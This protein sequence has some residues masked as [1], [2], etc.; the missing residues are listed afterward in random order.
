[1]I[2]RVAPFVFVPTNNIALYRS[3]ERLIVSEI[4]PQESF[5][6]AHE[7]LILGPKL[8][9]NVGTDRRPGT[10]RRTDGD[11]RGIRDTVS[12]RPDDVNRAHRSM[13][14]SPAQTLIQWVGADFLEI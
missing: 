2:L 14:P 10:E 7:S 5:P 8:E 13:K 3:L 9:G 4:W 11:R 6:S 12:C 1:M